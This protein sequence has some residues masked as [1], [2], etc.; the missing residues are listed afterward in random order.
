MHAV[1][2]NLGGSP[3]GLPKKKEREKVGWWPAFAWANCQYNMLGWNKNKR[4]V[5]I[6]IDTFFFV[7]R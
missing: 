2:F 4:T 5:V 6:K 1:N 7:F 3:S